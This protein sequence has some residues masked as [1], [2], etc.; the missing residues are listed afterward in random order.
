MIEKK[1][2]DDEVPGTDFLKKQGLKLGKDWNFIQTKENGYSI[3]AALNKQ[4]DM[5]EKVCLV[6]NT[7]PEDQ[8]QV[9]AGH[10]ESVKK[11]AQKVM[12]CYL[13]GDSHKISEKLGETVEL[14]PLV[15]QDTTEV[16][17]SFLSGSE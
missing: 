17:A 6:Y 12:V 7:L 15:S 1:V 9:V 13:Q 8:L 10:V 11:T 16:L 4:E 3:A 5:P 2:Q 14:I